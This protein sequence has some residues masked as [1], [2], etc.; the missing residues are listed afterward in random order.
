MINS[1]KTNKLRDDVDEL[2][3]QTILGYIQYVTAHENE[4][5]SMHKFAIK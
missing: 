2:W 4:I 5:K 3:M 1:S